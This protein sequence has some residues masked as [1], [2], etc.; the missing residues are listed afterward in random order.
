[1]VGCKTG[2]GVLCVK[3]A[4]FMALE[5][6][7]KH[8]YFVNT[9]SIKQVVYLEYEIPDYYYPLIDG[10]LT[11]EGYRY[12]IIFQL[13]E[14]ENNYKVARGSKQSAFLTWFKRN[15]KKCEWGKSLTECV[16]DIMQNYEMQENYGFRRMHGGFPYVYVNL[17]E[18]LDKCK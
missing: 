12:D 11:D 8:D 4:G 13:L 1:M 7:I 3:K 16:T 15:V 18:W 6:A 10:K 5:D 17:K 2:A 14:D 9:G